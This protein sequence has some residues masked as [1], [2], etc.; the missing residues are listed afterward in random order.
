MNNTLSHTIRSSRLRIPT[1]VQLGS[2]H[3]EPLAA[4]LPP[5]RWKKEL[6]KDGPSIGCEGQMLKP[7]SL[8]A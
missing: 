7:F 3:P 1:L 5:Q 4:W 2:P 8:E 6:G